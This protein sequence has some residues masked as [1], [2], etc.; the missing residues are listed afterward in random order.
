MCKLFVD[1]KNE[2]HEYCMENGLDFSKAEK[3]GKC[4][5]EDVLMLQ[6]I[7]PHKGKNGL[8]DE[9]P[10]PVMLVIRKVGNRLVFEQTEHTKCYLS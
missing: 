4:W 1:W 8:Q 2:I 6:H 5:G 10:A 7:D 3:A 9:T